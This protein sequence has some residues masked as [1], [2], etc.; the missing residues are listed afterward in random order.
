M[1]RKVEKR[2]QGGVTNSSAFLLE[3]IIEAEKKVPLLDKIQA[4][5]V[6]AESKKRTRGNIAAT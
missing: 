5:K 2:S 4:E 3:A 1:Q 6:K